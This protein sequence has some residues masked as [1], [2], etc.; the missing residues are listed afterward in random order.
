MV[1][2]LYG[3]KGWFYERQFFHKW[4]GGP[5]MIQPHY[6]YCALHLYYY[7]IVMYKGIVIQLTQH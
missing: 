6:I 4:G 7:Y 3:T 5:G 1:L 2:K